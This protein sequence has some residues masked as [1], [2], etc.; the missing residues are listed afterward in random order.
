MQDTQLS[1]PFKVNA[2]FIMNA[3]MCF[4]RVT[5]CRPG[6]AVNDAADAADSDSHW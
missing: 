1:E 6:M 2:S 3:Y 5:G 4:A